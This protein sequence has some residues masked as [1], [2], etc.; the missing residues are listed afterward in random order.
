MVDTIYLM[1]LSKDEAWL[2]NALR[3]K[4]SMMHCYFCEQMFKPSYWV[5]TKCPHESQRNVLSTSFAYELSDLQPS[6]TITSR[7]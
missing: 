5:H 4:K 7:Q 6:T 3:S 2:I 1:E